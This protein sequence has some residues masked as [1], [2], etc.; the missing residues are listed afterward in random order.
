MKI[1]KTKIYKTVIFIFFALFRT[2]NPAVLQTNWFIGS[3]LTE[4]ALIYSVR[5]KGVFWR[6]KRPA[7]VLIALSIFAVLATLILPFLKFGQKLFKFHAPSAEHLMMIFAVVGIYFMVTELIKIWYYR[8][9]DNKKSL[10]V[11]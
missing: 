11:I 2:H 5:T 7:G 9:V 4:I 8:S 1:N 3:V 6:A 10:K